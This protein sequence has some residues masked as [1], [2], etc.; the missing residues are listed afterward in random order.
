MKQLDANNQSGISENLHAQCGQ[1]LATTTLN[2]LPVNEA[3]ADDVKGGSV[4]TGTVTF[5]VDGALTRPKVKTY[6]CPSDTV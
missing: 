1:A 6:L 3:Q 2:D 4:P 5:Q